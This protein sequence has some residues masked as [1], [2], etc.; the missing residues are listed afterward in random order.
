MQELL[1]DLYYGKIHP[2]SEPLEDLDGY[3]KMAD[4]L[5]RNEKNLMSTLSD[6]QGKLYQKV[7]QKQGELNVFSSEQKFIQGFK[8]GAKLVIE[9]MNDDKIT[10]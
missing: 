8:L 6:S 9:I 10:E 1:K 3:K 2:L 7:S 4:I 5:S